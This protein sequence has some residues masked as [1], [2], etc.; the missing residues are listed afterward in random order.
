MKYS[1]LSDEQKIDLLQREQDD[2]QRAFMLRSFSSDELKL[3]YIH[4]V[5]EDENK[6]LVTYKM[7]DEVNKVKIIETMQDEIWITIATTELSSNQLKI[8]LLS[9]VKNG[10][11]K[12]CIIRSTKEND[13]ELIDSLEYV[14]DEKDKAFILTR[15]TNDK[16]KLKYL[17]EIKDDINKS[18]IIMTI[19]DDDLK[20][21]YIEKLD[22]KCAKSFLIAS[23]KNTELR[24]K[25]TEGIKK[26]YTNIS[27]PHGMTVG[28]EIEC[29][30]KN[31]VD[32][33]LISDILEGWDSKMDSS[34]QEGVEITS[35]ILSNAKKDT[36]TLFLVCNVLQELGENTSDRCGA[37]IHIGANYLETK[38]SYANLIELWSN[39]EELMFLLSN[40]VGEISREGIIK[41]ASPISM[42]ILKDIQGNEFNKYDSLDK[43]Q[44]IEKIKYLQITEKGQGTKR[45]GINFLTVNAENRNI[46]TIEFRVSNGT[47]DANT[48]IENANFFGGLV[49]ISQEISNIQNKSTEEIDD[50]DKI[51]L[52]KF[53]KLKNINL[54]NEEKLD[55]LLDLCV[56]EE[57]KKI[58]VDRYTE[59]SRL[60][61]ENK[62][63]KEGLNAHITDK[64]I[65]FSISSVR[66]ISKNSRFSEVK[67]VKEELI[68]YMQKKMARFKS[69]LYI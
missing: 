6:S 29:E 24:N 16:L 36:D 50:R 66:N 63:V 25:Y 51:I 57:M 31:S 10:Y 9:K 52:E 30:G 53:T 40:K 2:M 38:E 47:I 39:N 32:A 58:Y 49:A 11:Y 46:N 7:T 4:L 64:P 12:N 21:E 35:P 37:H 20:V 65:E 61:E 62:K 26:K 48:W 28:M 69:N 15:L 54:S 1:N 3:K 55:M 41:Y 59:N 5:I 33:Y 27:I 19:D 18:K 42:K 44:F 22:D 43:I 34:L 17:S 8:K 68:N 60:L 67:K 56:P 23:L 45:K 14:E 13:K